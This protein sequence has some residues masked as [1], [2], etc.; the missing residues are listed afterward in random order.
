MFVRVFDRGYDFVVV[1]VV[2]VVVRERNRCIQLLRCFSPIYGPYLF[3]FF[4]WGGRFFLSTIA[5]CISSF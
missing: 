4:F 5:F 1:I 3:F 2:V